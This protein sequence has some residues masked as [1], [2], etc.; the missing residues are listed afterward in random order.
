MRAEVRSLAPAL[1]PSVQSFVM[2]WE[3]PQPPV[4]DYWIGLAVVI[5]VPLVA[6]YLLYLLLS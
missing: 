3:D 4:F 2:S 6:G 5:L 1:P